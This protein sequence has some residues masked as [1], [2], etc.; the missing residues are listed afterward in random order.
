MVTTYKVYYSI[1][2]KLLISFRRKW[3][4]LYTK[5]TKKY[6]VAS[7]GAVFHQVLRQ[8][9]PSSDQRR[10]IKAVS[11]KVLSLANRMARKYKG[12]AILAG[13]LTRDTWLPDK[14]EFDVF[15]CFPEKMKESQMEKAGLGIGAAIARKLKAESKVEYAEHPYTDI[16]YEGVDIDVVPCYSV[17]SAEKI[18]SSVDRTPF[19]VQYIEKHLPTRLSDQVRLFKQFLKAAKIYG[20]DAKYEGLSG[21][22]CELLTIRYNGFQNL[23]KAISKWQAGEIIDL[24]EVYGK[25]N[26]GEVKKK[27]WNQPLVV[28]DPTDKNRN[29]AAAL[30]MKNF[31]LLKKRV[32]DF[33]KKPSVEFFLPPTP[34]PIT[35]KEL[36]N[37]QSQRRTETVVVKFIPPKVVPDILWPQ[38]RKFGERLQNILEETRYEFK[39][40]NRGEFSDEKFI[41]AV[42]LELEVAHLP[43][44]QKRIGPSIFAQKESKEFLDKYLQNPTFAGPYV[45]DGTWV[46]ETPRQFLSA[47][48]KLLDSLSKPLDVL[49]AKGIPDKIAERLVT[50][51]EIISETEK[52]LEE[53]KRNPDFGIYLKQFF[54]KVKLV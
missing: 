41:A 45:E 35:E 12:K 17:Q 9:K 47:H 44:V 2:A 36:A 8:I 48:D 32:A 31:F 38:L 10:K 39:V 4:S 21:Y 24:E 25:K 18:K 14:L 5:S 28:I 22:T 40:M 50:G 34:E 54:Q 30:S 49:Q 43:A 26:I 15:V 20:A 6:N 33:L 29:T 52:I 53:A 37:L 3:K 16:T 1:V 7:S 23:L 42:V 13:S 27:F 19:H 51:F 11:H 46:V